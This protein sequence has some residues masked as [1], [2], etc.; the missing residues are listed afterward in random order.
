ML[1]PESSVSASTAQPS[2][3]TDSKAMSP[4]LAPV[5]AT[6]HETK[7]MPCLPQWLSFRPSSLVRRIG[8]VVLLLV[9]WFLFTGLSFGAT[10][11]FLGGY[12][13]DIRVKHGMLLLT[14]ILV[15]YWILKNGA[16]L[17]WRWPLPSFFIL[18]LMIFRFSTISDNNIEAVD[19][20]KLAVSAILASIAFGLLIAGLFQFSRASRR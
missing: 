8:C 15:A 6:H 20:A 19:V 13:A 2:A 16:R 10:E 3:P 9:G 4:K 7:S 1:L 18:S 14:G 12:P 5:A 17:W 11:L